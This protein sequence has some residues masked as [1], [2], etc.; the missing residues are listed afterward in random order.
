MILSKIFE[1][2]GIF[3]V[4]TISSFGYFGVFI[5]M[6]M[7]SMI[8]PMPAELVMPFAGFIAYQGKFNFLLVIVA[9]SL[10]SITGSLISYYIGYYGGNK[11]LMKYGKYVLV[12]PD[13]L[14]KTNEWFNKRGSSTIF[15]SRFIPVVRHLISIPAGMGKMSLGKFCFYTL[16]GATIYN[17]FLAYLGYIL[18]MKWMIIRQ[19]SEPFSIA[20]ALLVLAGIIYFLY[21]HIRR[22]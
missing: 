15:I 13:D 2:I 7:E 22:N 21:K 17:V 5:L 16:A 12:N 1:A 3:A 8:I 14:K 4:N 9:S 20:A 18:G 11:F 10:G 19:Y 6:A